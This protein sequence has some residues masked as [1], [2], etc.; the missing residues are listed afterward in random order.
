MAYLNS[1][2]PTTKILVRKEFL[3]DQ[4]SHKD[5]YEP[6]WIVGVT[7]IPGYC[8]MVHVLLENGALF[9]R[10]P[11]H[12]IVWK[13]IEQG[14][15]LN[16]LQVWNCFS[17][18]FTVYSYDFLCGMRVEVYMKDKTWHPGTYIT[19]VDWCDRDNQATSNFSAMPDQ[20]KAGYLIQLDSGHY[21]LQPTNRLRWSDPGL[22]TKPFPERPD[23]KVQTQYYSCE[24]E[25]KWVT[26][27]SDK[28]FY[29]IEASFETSS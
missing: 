21:A 3:Y 20:Y 24:T 8:L 22:I 23:Y 13:E 7:S 12:A 5:K 25:T 27:D 10:L 26:E 6:G 2:F 15:P 9:G 11:F 18:D 29:E 4:Q 19:T 17:Y 28:F 16:Y 1:S 14:I